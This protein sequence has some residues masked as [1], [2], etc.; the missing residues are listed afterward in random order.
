MPH[1]RLWRRLGRKGALVVLFGFMF[2]IYGLALCM[3]ARGGVPE[4]LA[5]ALWL[6][7]LPVWSSAWMAVGLTGIVSAVCRRLDVAFTVL[8]GMPLVWS[9][10]GLGSWALFGADRAWV[11]AALF[12][13]WS[14]AL[15]LCSG[16]LEPP[17]RTR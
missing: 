10:L 8:V 3:P 2:T 7:P 16:L 9:L 5:A 12:A 13:P 6:A 15:A 17:P 1:R 11:L 4:V 14:A